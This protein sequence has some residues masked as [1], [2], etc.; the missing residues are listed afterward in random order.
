MP[1][2]HRNLL[3]IFFALLIVSVV[4]VAPASAI[5]VTRDIAVVRGTDSGVYWNS[6]NSAASWGSWASL[7]GSTP[8]P[9]G[10]CQSAGSSTVVAIVRGTDNGIYTKYSSAGTWSS[11][12]V[13]PPGGGATIDQPACAYLPGVLYV[14]VRGAGGELYWNSFNGASWSG[15]A[16]LHGAIRL[17]SRPGFNAAWVSSVGLTW[18]FRVRITASTTK[19]TR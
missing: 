6:Y 3:V 1:F 14:V 18:S 2:S 8:S 9:P 15:W 10:I 11:S 5:P 13:S 16:D 12:W 17:R 7:S 4:E 19:P